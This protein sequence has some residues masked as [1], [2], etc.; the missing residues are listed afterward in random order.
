[1]PAWAIRLKSLNPQPSDIPTTKFMQHFQQ[2][3][4]A[5]RQASINFK[6]YCIVSECQKQQEQKGTARIRGGFVPECTETG[7][8]RQLQ[9][10]TDAQSC[11]CVDSSG[12]EIPK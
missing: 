1:M 10:E 9:C 3:K 5:R 7:E 11:F 2:M 6:N 12:I 4:A 8:F